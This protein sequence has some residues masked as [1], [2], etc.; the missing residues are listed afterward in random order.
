[1]DEKTAWVVL[2]IFVLEACA[3]YTAVRLP[4]RDVTELNQFEKIND[5]YVGISFMDKSQTK[6]YFD[7]DLI[8]KGVQ[9]VYVVIEN[10]SKKTYNFSKENM[11]IPGLDSLETAKQGARSTAGRAVGYGLASLILWPLLIPAIGDSIA[12][13]KANKAMRSDYESKEIAD[14]TIRPMRS[15]YGVVFA[16]VLKSGEEISITLIKK[17]T[18]E[19]VIFRFKE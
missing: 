19:R 6:R 3:S 2:S 8:E 11:G 9:P 15:K 4:Q 7:A 16:P 12:S 10:G 18:K 5:V 13:S 14:G 1:M 17:E